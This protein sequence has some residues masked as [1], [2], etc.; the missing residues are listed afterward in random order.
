MLWGYVFLCVFLGW[1]GVCEIG[2]GP[3]PLRFRFLRTL[4]YFFIADEE[5]PVFTECP[6]DIEHELP[7]GVFETEITWEEPSAI[8]NSGILPTLSSTH[9]SGDSFSVGEFTVEYTATDEN[10]NEGSCSFRI[11]VHG[12]SSIV[13]YS[14]V[15]FIIISSLKGK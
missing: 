13:F 3:P 10:G 15:L 2:Q 11:T 8:D 7:R 5:A 6:D 12:E 1:D 4:F 9:N 14:V